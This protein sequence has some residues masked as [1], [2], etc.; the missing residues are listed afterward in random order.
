MATDF[1]IVGGGI[2]GAVLAR[3]LGVQGKRVLVLEKEARIASHQTAHNSGVIHAGIY[4]VPGS[5]K[6]S[7]CVAGSREICAYCDEK[8]IPYERCGKVVVATTEAE[9]SP[10]E[11]LHRRAKANGVPGVELLPL[12]T[13]DRRP[14]GRLRPPGSR[15]RARHDRAADGRH[16]HRHLR[17]AS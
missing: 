3:R 8:D 16:A 5:L 17:R 10:L 15:A 9:L 1:L 11:E 7:L 13:E 12:A 14:S 6:A 2:G 4:Y